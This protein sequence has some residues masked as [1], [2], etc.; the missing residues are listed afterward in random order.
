VSWSNLRIAALPGYEWSR[1]PLEFL[2]F[3]RSRV[4]PKRQAFNELADTV[5]QQPDLLCIPWYQQSHITRILRWV[6]SRPPRVQTMMTLLAG[7][8]PR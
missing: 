5:T 4:M 7:Q 3:A 6:T 8:A 2:R 1:T